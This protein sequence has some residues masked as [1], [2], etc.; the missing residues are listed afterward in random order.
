MVTAHST[1]LTT[2]T[3]DTSITLHRT[4]VVTSQYGPTNKHTVVSALLASEANGTHN[5]P[6]HMPHFPLF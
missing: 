2:V 1:H 6:L 3:M 4:P 5:I